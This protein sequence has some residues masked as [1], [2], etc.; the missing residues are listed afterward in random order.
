MGPDTLVSA[1]ASGDA[2]LSLGLTYAVAD[3]AALDGPARSVLLSGSVTVYR[4][5]AQVWGD[6]ARV[7]LE[8]STVRVSPAQGRIEVPVRGKE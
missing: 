7:G 5:A 4:D 1:R 2:R 8:D 6:S 3:E